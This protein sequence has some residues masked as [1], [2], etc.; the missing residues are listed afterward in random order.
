MNWFVLIR[1]LAASNF[2]GHKSIQESKGKLSG[3]GLHAFRGI[4]LQ[5]SNLSPFHLPVDHHG[6][7][8]CRWFVQ[9]PHFRDWCQAQDTRSWYLKDG[10]RGSPVITITIAWQQQT[11]EKFTI[12]TI[13]TGCVSPSLIFVCPLSIPGFWI[14]GDFCFAKWYRKFEFGWGL[15]A[16][17]PMK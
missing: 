10:L 11:Q 17:L 2:F 13:A 12:M 14:V 16:H 1:F 5:E 9:L 8:M 3:M 7:Q 4:S 6:D 15:S